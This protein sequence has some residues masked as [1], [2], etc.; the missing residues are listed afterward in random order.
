MPDLSPFEPAKVDAQRLAKRAVHRAVDFGKT[1]TTATLLKTLGVT[2]VAGIAAVLN[3]PAFA[4][5]A[6]IGAFIAL[7]VYVI[8]ATKLLKAQDGEARWT[9]VSGKRVQQS[10]IAS[11]IAM[12]TVTLA[13]MG[14]HHAPGKLRNAS[15][16]LRSALA[17]HQ[18]R[19]R[20]AE[21]RA[22]AAE[23]VKEGTATS[24][25]RRDLVG[26]QRGRG[27][28]PPKGPALE[29]IKARREALEAERAALEA[30]IQSLS[31]AENIVKAMEAE[32][33][34][35]TRRTKRERE[36][37]ARKAD[38][39][40]RDRVRTG[41][42]PTR[43]EPEHVINLQVAA[44]GTRDVGTR[45]GPLTPEEIAQGDDQDDAA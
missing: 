27:A 19:L 7:S 39:A 1:Y 18:N 41:K 42:P 37:A 20:Q 33:V 6:V 24:K 3:F 32:E 8:Y 34:K 23:A 26:F 28:A 11:K 5:V 2:V 31:T 15:A 14:E 22:D 35:G 13:L 44:N 17:Y 29:P 30:E 9:Y 43:P 45:R 21:Q 10:V 16:E 12:D 36:K 25:Q 4:A 38:Q 40:A